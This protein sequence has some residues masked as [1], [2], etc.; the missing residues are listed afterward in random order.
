MSGVLHEGPRQ[1]AGEALRRA[2]MAALEAVPGLGGVYAGT[3]LQAA[4]PYAA[5]DTGLESDWSHKSGKGREVRLAATLWDKGERPAR[6]PTLMAEAEAALE[7][8]GGEIGAWRL[9]TMQFLRSRT[10]REP[11]GAGPLGPGAAWA[12]VIEFR[13][14]LLAV[15]A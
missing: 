8:L 4:A 2:A 13:A 10:V 9:V 14:R 3:P 6:L 1:G 15:G 7:A 12:G 5:V 11:R